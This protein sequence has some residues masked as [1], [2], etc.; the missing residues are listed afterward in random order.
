M[1]GGAT[2]L[3]G[4]YDMLDLGDAWFRSL[5]DK[6]YKFKNYDINKD[7]EHGY[8]SRIEERAYEAAKKFFVSGYPTQLQENLYYDAE[9]L[10]MN[11]YKE[12]YEDISNRK[13]GEY[14]EKTCV[15]NSKR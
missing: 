6:G 10:A 15:R 7:S 5:I 3:F 1:P 4:S 8:F 14:R 2:P 11:Y 12:N 9:S 13:R